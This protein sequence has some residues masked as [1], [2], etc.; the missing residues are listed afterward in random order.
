[1]SLIH[2]WTVN[3]LLGCFEKCVKAFQAERHDKCTGNGNEHDVLIPK[4]F[5]YRIVPLNI[6]VEY[7]LH[8]CR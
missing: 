8:M 6:V 1:M 2:P 4:R 5:S 7:G 3:D